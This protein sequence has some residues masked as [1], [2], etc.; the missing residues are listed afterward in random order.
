LNK[1]DNKIKEK[2]EA[3]PLGFFPLRLLIRIF[4]IFCGT[5]CF[6]G[7]FPFAPGSFA[8]LVAFLALYFSD[9]SNGFY[10]II[11]AII[12]FF[13]GVFVSSFLE[14]SWGKDAKYIVID[15]VVGMLLSIVFLPKTFI[16]W[17]M[18]FLIFRIFD[19]LKPYPLKRFEE[20]KGGWGVMIDDLG[21]AI[22]TSILMNIAV[23]GFGLI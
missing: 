19:V 8:S 10:L 22:Y 4:I 15:E 1:I 2:T 20:F 18:A 9:L 13:V 6:I 11:F 23:W 14:K 17:G 3:H 21:A 7:Y 12:L 16:I 5:V